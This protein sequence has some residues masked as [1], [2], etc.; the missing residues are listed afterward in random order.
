VS[1]WRRITEAGASHG[2]HTAGLAWRDTLGLEAGM[3]LYRNE[4]S[5]ELTH[6]HAGLGR[7]V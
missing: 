3:P 6:F 4:L 2:L 7:T 1:V 5:S